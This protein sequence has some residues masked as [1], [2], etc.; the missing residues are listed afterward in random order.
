MTL[1]EAIDS[2]R[3]WKHRTE[4]YWR[5]AGFPAPETHALWSTS[6][7]ISSEFEIEPEPKKPR[8][9]LI[10]TYEN[11]YIHGCKK[12]DHS[13]HD[14]IRVHDADA[15]DRTHFPCGGNKKPGRCG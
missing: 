15:C 10:H 2:G 14:P 9:W 4:G 11:G 1:K 7:A 3:R 6:L 5:D 12:T 8:E 13:C